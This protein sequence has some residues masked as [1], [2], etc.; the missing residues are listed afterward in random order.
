MGFVDG[1]SFGYGWAVV[2]EPKGS[3]DARRAI[4]T[5]ARSAPGWIDPKSDLFMV[6]LIQRTG[7]ANGDAS[8]MRKTLQELAVKSV[9]R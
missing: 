5:A 1:M 2:N 6:L 3:R 8:P 4:F 7:L 9:E